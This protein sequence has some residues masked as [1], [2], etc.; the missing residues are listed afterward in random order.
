MSDGIKQ[1][2]YGRLRHSAP[3]LAVPDR[4]QQHVSELASFAG[5]TDARKLGYGALAFWIVV[6]VLLAA[7]IA[8]L[9]PNRIQPTSS[10]FETKATPVWIAA[11]SPSAKN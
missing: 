7:R 10:L 5:G 6:A 3:G 9:D 1:G 4:E 8:F 2:I 11:Q